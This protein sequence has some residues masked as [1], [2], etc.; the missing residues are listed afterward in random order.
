MEKCA[1]NDPSGKGTIEPQ[2][3]P[4]YQLLAL[5]EGLVADGI[6]SNMEADLLRACLS[7]DRG[8]SASD[9]LA[10]ADLLVS[11]MISEGKLSNNERRELFDNLEQLQ[12]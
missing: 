11:R 7:A 5:C 12:S 10:R 1:Y 3:S 4:L 8:V 6:L 9:P 2:V